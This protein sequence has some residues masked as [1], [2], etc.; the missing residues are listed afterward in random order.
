VAFD[1]LWFSTVENAYQAAKERTRQQRMSYLNVTPFKAKKMGRELH[2]RE[3]W[4]DIKFDVMH[5]LV[6][7]KFD[8]NK[9]LGDK[10]L[11]TGD[12]QIVEGN[13]WGDTYWGVCNGDGEN[14]IGKIIMDVRTSLRL[15]Y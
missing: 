8:N 2:L 7:Q 9:S 11:A 1:G 13:D 15:K 14:N 3:G 5:D 4:E 6:F 12:V 10:L